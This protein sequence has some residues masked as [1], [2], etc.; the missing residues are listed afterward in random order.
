M[1]FELL[2]SLSLV[3]ILFI[4]S[5]NLSVNE[6]VEPLEVCVMV[7]R[8]V[9]SAVAFSLTFVDGTAMGMFNFRI[10]SGE[11]EERVWP[12]KLHRNFVC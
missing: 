8:P 5:G 9:I 12:M 4:S 7:D 2:I 1:N 11:R 3:A 10:V 6:T